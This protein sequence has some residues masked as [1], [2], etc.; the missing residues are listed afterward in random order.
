MHAAP[1][2]RPPTPSAGAGDSPTSP[3]ASGGPVPLTGGGTVYFGR[4]FPIVW[5]TA[6]GAATAA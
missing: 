5:T 2:P 3:E 4:V 1:T 6:M